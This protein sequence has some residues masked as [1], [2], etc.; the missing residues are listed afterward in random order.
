[1]AGCC[2]AAPL[3]L[4]KASVG[5]WRRA[6]R[7]FE[8]GSAPSAVARGGA[9]ETAVGAVGRRKTVDSVR[10]RGVAVTVA[11]GKRA[12]RAS[13]RESTVVDGKVALGTDDSDDGVLPAAP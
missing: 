9:A 7:P 11:T 2:R 13:W 12:P 3:S 1:M 6:L 5:S 8:G 4:G 10:P